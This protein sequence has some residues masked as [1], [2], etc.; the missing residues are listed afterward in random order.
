VSARTRPHTPG[1]ALLV[2][3][4]PLV[5]CITGGEDERLEGTWRL[6]EDVDQ[7]CIQELVFDG[8]D[9]KESTFCRLATGQIGLEVKGGV[10]RADAGQIVFTYLRSSC[11]DEVRHEL[12]LSYEINRRMLSLSTPEYAIGLPRKQSPAT[13]TGTSVNGCFEEDMTKFA[14]SPLREL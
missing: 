6:G 2:A 7:A 1:L 14:P 4:L 5:A 13:V 9:F 10:Y 11:P 12:T 8:G 3:A